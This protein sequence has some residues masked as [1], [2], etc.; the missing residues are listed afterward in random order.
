MPFLHD[1]ISSPNGGMIQVHPAFPAVTCSAQATYLTGKAPGVHGI[2]G[3]NIWNPDLGE[4]KNWHQ[5]A[6]LVQCP[7]IFEKLKL[8]DP[9]IT[10]FSNCW[11]FP[12]GDRFLDY[13]ITP[14]PQYLANGGKVADIWTKPEHLRHALQSP[15]SE[16]G[17]GT[18]PLHRFWGPGANIASTEWIINAS[19]LV[20]REHNPTFS[21]I[22]LPHLD[23]NLQKLGPNPDEDPSGTIK[24]DIQR[25]DQELSRLV[26]YYHQAHP[27]V[28]ILILSEYGIQP[29]HKPIHINRYLKNWGYLST[30]SSNGGEN[31]DTYS[32]TAFALPDHQVAHIYVNDQS[33]ESVPEQ[34]AHLPFPMSASKLSN[35]VK[36]QQALK[37]VPG[38]SAVLRRDLGEVDSYYSHPTGFGS[39]T[40]PK[41]TGDIVVIADADAWFTYYFWRNDNDSG[42]QGPPDYAK[43]VAIHAKPGYDPVEMFYAHPHPILGFMYLI[44]KVFL[45]YVLHL[46]VTVDGTRF[47]AELIRG[48]HGITKNLH[49]KYYPIIASKNLST[50]IKGSAPSIIFAEEVYDVMWK[51]VTSP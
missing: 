13:C 48:S 25:I 42:T 1:Y 41:R 24:L 38:I 7:R 46:R 22:Y 40:D 33:Q 21:L 3:N 10:T 51:L 31:L 12:M 43:C 15:K 49:T 37:K 50:C 20:D 34:C 14:R 9:K 4:Y 16:G 5:S 47:R 32:S 45:V 35:V 2:V 28:R 30:R 36:L 44:W 19:I 26:T 6:H 18:F 11:W 29:V 27:S 23:Y 17:L 39:A 8:H